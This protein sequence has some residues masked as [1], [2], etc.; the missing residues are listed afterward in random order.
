MT[1]RFG[2]ATVALA[3]AVL[4]GCGDL[5]AD[6]V[7]DLATTF[8]RAD[9]DPGTRC[10]LLASTTLAAV[11]QDGPC[12]DVLAELPLGSG[13]V[14]AIEVWGEEAQVKLSDDTL[15]LT[16]TSDGWRVSAAAC[17]PQGA[18]LPY[19]CDVEAS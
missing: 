8:A 5:S 14:T 17:T 10:E 19:D 3:V 7:E 18:D 12:D 9:D 6:E 15:F 11:Q 4:T 1:T 2:L 13:D 16:R